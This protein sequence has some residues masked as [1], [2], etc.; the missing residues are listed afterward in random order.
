M[1]SMAK[2]TSAA[3]TDNHGAY[4]SDMRLGKYSFEPEWG[5]ETVTIENVVVRPGV[6]RTYIFGDVSH[7]NYTIWDKVGEDGRAL[8]GA[9]GKPGKMVS[10]PVGW[11]ECSAE[12]IDNTD[13]LRLFRDT[14]RGAEGDDGYYVE[15]DTDS[16]GWGNVFDAAGKAPEDLQVVPMGNLTMTLLIYRSGYE[17]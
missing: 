4:K 9:R 13:I 7:P 6:W 16:P 5:E 10:I 14:E 3:P 11:V 1:V 8:P 2:N 17:G 15:Y 12:S